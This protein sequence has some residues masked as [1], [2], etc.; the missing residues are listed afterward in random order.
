MSA[1]VVVLPGVC[2]KRGDPAHPHDCI[3]TPGKDVM[4]YCAVRAY[5]KSEYLVGGEDA[6]MRYVCERVATP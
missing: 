5:A 1:V 6:M 3:L 2:S 4:R